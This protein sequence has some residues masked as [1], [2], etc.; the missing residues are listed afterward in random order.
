[1]PKGLSYRKKINVN[2]VPFHIQEKMIEFII[3]MAKMSKTHPDYITVEEL[4]LIIKLLRDRFIE[5]GL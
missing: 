1:M 4:K 5:A 2:V 3:A